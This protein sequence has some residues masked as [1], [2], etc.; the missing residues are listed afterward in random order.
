MFDRDPADM[1]IVVNIEQSVFIEVFGFGH[2]DR[3]KLYIECVRVLEVLDL[4]GVNVRSK[5]AL[6]WGRPVELWVR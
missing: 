1:A 6:G 4:P 3:P 2:F 5:N